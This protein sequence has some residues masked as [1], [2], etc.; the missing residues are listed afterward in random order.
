MDA[1]EWLVLDTGFRRAKS[2]GTRRMSLEAKRYPILA[3]VTDGD[4]L[5]T[6]VRLG[7]ERGR[8]VA[9]VRPN[10]RLQSTVT[11]LAVPTGASPDQSKTCAA[12]AL[13]SSQT[14][15]YPAPKQLRNIRGF[16]Y[17]RGLLCPQ[18]AALP[19]ALCAVRFRS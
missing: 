12:V 15:D 6:A 19:S 11:T 1:S 14:L 7:F 13:G 17:S 8:G 18:F 4:K 2:L 10:R 3:G 5:E 16:P 9:G